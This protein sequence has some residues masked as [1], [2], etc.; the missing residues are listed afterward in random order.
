M[1]TTPD[2]QLNQN[3]EFDLCVL[4]PAY[5]EQSRIGTTLLDIIQT[6]NNWNCSAEILIADDGSTDD[7]VKVCQAIFAEHRL[8]S[9]DRVLSLS[10][11]MGKGAA[12]AH[13]LKNSRARWTIMMDADNSAHLSELPK[14]ASH[15]TDSG[16]HLSKSHHM[17]IGSRRMNTSQVHA[18]ITRVCVGLIYS[19]TL[20]ILGLRL[21]NDTQCGF[22][23]YSHH[24]ARLIADHAQEHGFSF[25]IEHLLIAKHAGLIVPEVG[26]LWDHVDGSKVNPVL[27]GL[28]MLSKIITMRRPVR[29]RVLPTRLPDPDALDLAHV[30]SDHASQIEIKINPQPALVKSI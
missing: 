20:R 24:A 26:I 19:F 25:D 8:H 13:G 22:K 30:D 17:I 10:K 29:Q 1:T 7:T 27:D 12:V 28:K 18:N 11:N 15:I 4:I 14:L 21:A 9:N 16:P 23:L 3:P 6:L 5:N 2:D